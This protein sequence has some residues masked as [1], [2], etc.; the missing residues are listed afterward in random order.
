MGTVPGAVSM[1]RQ[2]GAG[3]PPLHRVRVGRRVALG[4]F[5][6]LNGMIARHA[7]MARALAAQLGL[8][9]D[10]QHAV[11]ASYEQWDGKGWPGDLK[12]DAIPVAAR[13]PANLAEYVEVTHRMGGTE[14]ACELAR[15]RPGSQF[16]PDLAARVCA[17]PDAFLGGLDAM[18]KLDGVIGSEPAL[19]VTLSGE[20][21]DQALRAVA[22]FVNLKSPY[23]LGHAHAVA[24]LTAA[25]GTRLGFDGHSVA[26]LR[27]A[28]L[29]HDLGRARGV[30]RHLGQAGPTGDGRVGARAHAPVPDRADAAPG[31]IAG[32]A[33]RPSRCSTACAWTVR[34]TPA[35]C[36]ED[37]SAR[38]PAF[39]RSR[40]LPVD[41]RPRPHR[42]ALDQAAAAAELTADVR[43]GRLD[44][45]AVGAVLAAAGHRVPRRRPGPAG[46][47][48]RAIDV[49]RLLARGL[50][51][52][53]ISAR[54]VISPKT[55]R[56]H[57]EHIYTKIGATSRVQAS[58]FAVQH[59]LLP[60]GEIQSV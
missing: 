50:S 49:L 55:V 11:G 44:G 6:D 7:V 41:V 28:G 29:V 8:S 12:G 33:R 14:A 48:A 36:R 10:V 18:R 16:D 2:I 19:C 38:R 21:F 31:R 56:N 1:F 15:R 9:E 35:A 26:T 25:A 40:R 27:R 58:L 47:T 42:P 17:E 4:G 22:D 37:R 23:T 20:G 45:D 13:L 59:G 32:S 5:R 24:E 51:S 57:I 46:L 39:G 54:L 34:V 52:K 60:E 53:E 43:A 3:N 30:Q